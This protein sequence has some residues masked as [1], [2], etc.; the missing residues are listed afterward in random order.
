MLALLIPVFSITLG[1]RRI[2]FEGE[3]SDERDIMLS[4]TK[5]NGG[6]APAKEKGRK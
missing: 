1:K 4:F 6:K 3:V 5:E 2:T